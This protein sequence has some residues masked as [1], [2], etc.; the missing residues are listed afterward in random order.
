MRSLIAALASAAALLAAPPAARAAAQPPTILTAGI[1]AADHLYATWSL[2]AG[3]AFER[4][5]FATS[6]EPNPF[7][8][9][10]FV[11]DNIADVGCAGLDGCTATVATTSYTSGYPIARDRRYFVEVTAAAAGLQL[12]SAV[13]VIDEVKPLIA[14]E[15]PV[16]TPEL[17]TRSPATGRLFAPAPSASLRV[18][19]LPGS[20]AGV[21]R[22]AVRVRVRC[23]APCD[24]DLRLSL[25]GRTLVRRTGRLDGGASTALAFKPTGALRRDLR[26]RARAH[27]RIS[28][29]VTPL[30]GVTRR[31][32]RA[33]DVRR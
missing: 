1:D 17:P 3:T 10:F 6:P 27:L 21:L 23:A 8:A 33:F 11:D 26:G 18:L 22:G 19:A 7:L 12:T 28:G 20:I 4:V 30:G 25:D 2:G 5:A 32:S 24:V 14:G 9:G 29:F 13:W 31:V 16:G 15:A